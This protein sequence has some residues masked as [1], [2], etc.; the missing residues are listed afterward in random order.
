M[1]YTMPF[2][3]VFAYP[4]KFRTKKPHVVCG[5]MLHIGL[6]YHRNLDLD[7]RDYFVE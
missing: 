2:F 1:F 7:W 6:Q 5:K 4:T 3:L